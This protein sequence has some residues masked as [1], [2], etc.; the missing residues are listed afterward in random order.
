MLNTLSPKKLWRNANEFSL[1]IEKKAIEDE[2]SCYSALLNYCEDAD[3]E[4]DTVASLVNR[5]LKDKLEV[6]F[7]ELGLLKKQSSLYD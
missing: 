6:E 5:Q 1:F 2:T 7:A 3:V 4:P